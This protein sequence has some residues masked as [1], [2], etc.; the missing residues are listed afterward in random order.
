M[1]WMPNDCIFASNLFCN[2]IWMDIKSNYNKIDEKTAIQQPMDSKFN[3]IHKR[4]KIE[5]STIIFLHKKIY[6]GKK[7]CQIKSGLLSRSWF[8]FVILHKLATIKHI[9][10]E[11]ENI[12][13]PFWAQWTRWRD[14]ACCKHASIH[15]YAWKCDTTKVI[16]CGVRGDGDCN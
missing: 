16:S 3:T 2:L 4:K 8:S 13:C 14:C 5:R 12:K 10:R 7:P 9:R 11:K 15:R 6:K 1:I